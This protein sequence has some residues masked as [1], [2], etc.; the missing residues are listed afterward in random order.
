MSRRG[1]EDGIAGDLVPHTHSAMPNPSTLT[2]AP[3]T[4][5]IAIPGTLASWRMAWMSTRSA[6]ALLDDIALSLC[7]AHAAARRVALE[8]SQSRRFIV[9]ML[10][11]RDVE[12][13]R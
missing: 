4:V 11:G 6:G 8:A 10:V 9:R 3:R 5:A 13:D 12:R 2:S 1:L 7:R